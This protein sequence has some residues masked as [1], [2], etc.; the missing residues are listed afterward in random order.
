MGEITQTERAE[1]RRRE[2]TILLVEDEPLVALVESRVLKKNGYRVTTTSEA[3]DAITKT[4]AEMPDLV[5]M[6]IDLGCDEMDGTDAAERILDRCNLPVV[7]LTSHTEKEYVDR[8]RQVTRYGYVVKDSGE[9]V[10]IQSIETAL[11]LFQAHK[12]PS[13]NYA[14]LSAVSECNEEGK[15][16]RTHAVVRPLSG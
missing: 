13:E 11:E 15:V 9:F 8:A 2:R 3:E 4:V 16:V 7:F 6:D 12:D 14:E 5:L 1:E 10:L